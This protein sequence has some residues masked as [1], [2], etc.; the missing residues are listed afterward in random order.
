VPVRAR[1]ESQK[2]E[3]KAFVMEW[4]YKPKV[5]L[6]VWVNLIFIIFT[7]ASPSARVRMD[8]FHVHE[9]RV[10]RAGI[11][12]TPPVPYAPLPPNSAPSRVTV[13]N[14]AGRLNVFLNN[15]LT[16]VKKPGRTLLLSPSFTVDTRAGGQSPVVT[17][18]FIL[19]TNSDNEACPGAC[20]FVVNADGL[21]LYESAAGGDSSNGWTREK[22]PGTS[23]KMADGQIAET[24]PAETFTT[25][26]YY[27]KFV[28]IIS[29]RRVVVSFGPDKVELTHDQIE[30]LR[31][32]HRQLAPLGPAAE[33]QRPGPRFVTPS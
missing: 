32:M 28:E 26:I 1:R 19:L 31:D 27:D 29:A 2:S 7:M 23:T 17:L 12:E 18:R 25:Q 20:M 30:A 6:G 5:Q 22:I 13:S 15:D 14:A 10:E 33:E 21:R 9:R 4:F 16:L 8:G 11:N 3:G 24:L